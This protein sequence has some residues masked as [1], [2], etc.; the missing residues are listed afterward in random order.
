MTSLNKLDT[1]YI[2]TNL[3]CSYLAFPNREHSVP[4]RLFVRNSFLV[5]FY[6][7]SNQRFQS[8]SVGFSAGSS[9]LSSDNAHISLS[10][11]LDLKSEGGCIRKST[12]NKSIFCENFVK[13][14][15]LVKREKKKYRAMHY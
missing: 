2:A 14:K 10:H 13:T 12:G 1:R 7:N 5:N 9:H 11:M 6:S 4:E 8:Q 15:G 3:R